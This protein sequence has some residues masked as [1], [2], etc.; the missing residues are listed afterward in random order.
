VAACR[1]FSVE[2]LQAIFHPD[3]RMSGFL[4]DQCLV[5][6]PQ[7]FFDA[8]RSAAGSG[9]PSDYGTE[10]TSVAVSGRVAAVTLEE[11][12]FLGMDFVDYFHL[13]K[14]DDGWKIVSKTFTTR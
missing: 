11:R 5:G 10:I 2:R 4:G 13:V 6:S 9:A 3:A 1:A 7:P 8:V 14:F 12:G